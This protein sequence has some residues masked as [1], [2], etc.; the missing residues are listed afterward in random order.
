[1]PPPTTVWIDSVLATFS[2][3]PKLAALGLHRGATR[4]T[5]L[6]PA[7]RT[8]PGVGPTAARL[9]WP[10]FIGGAC[11]ATSTVALLPRSGVSQVTFAASLALDPIV[12]R[13]GAFVSIGGFNESYSVRGAPELGMEEELV[14][15]LWE[16]GHCVGVAC[17]AKGRLFH[18]GCGGRGTWRTPAARE[19]RA[20][21]QQRNRG[22]FSAAFDGPR[23][24][25]VEDLVQA[26]NSELHARSA[27]GSRI[28]KTLRKLWPGG[29]ISNCASLLQLR[30]Q[31]A[32]HDRR[33]CQA[34]T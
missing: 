27:E 19:A 1:M 7:P 14:P 29:C 23:G 21:A 32:E 8:A 25:R 3:M 6:R 20:Q 31:T 28:R 26:A 12:V 11:N 24:A 17:G 30:R 15:K 22:L 10:A 2:A 5:Y 33:W 9:P 4:F 18:R 34:A 16:A 13:R